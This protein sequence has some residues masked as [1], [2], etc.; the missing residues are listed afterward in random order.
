LAAHDKKEKGKKKQ[1]RSN[2]SAKEALAAISSLAIL[3]KCSLAAR[4]QYTP[5]GV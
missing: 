2:P 4:L 3:N 1:Q 5:Q